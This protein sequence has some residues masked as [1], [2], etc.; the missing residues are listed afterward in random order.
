M[1]GLDFVEIKTN[2]IMEKLHSISST[3]QDFEDLCDTL[4][5]HEEKE[6]IPF[7]T[8]DVA[9]LNEKQ[10]DRVDAA[11]ELSENLSRLE[12]VFVN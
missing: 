7:Y 10:K 1:S 3:L 9:A 5:T 4:Q 2:Q 12:R 8:K 6:L 11:D